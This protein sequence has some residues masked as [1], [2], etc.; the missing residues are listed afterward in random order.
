[1]TPTTRDS[2]K[3]TIRVA[4][5]MGVAGAIASVVGLFVDRERFFH[6]YL[7]AWFFWLGFP[8][9]C[10]GILL[11]HHLLG[12][13][14]GIVTRRLFEAGAATMPLMALLSVPLLFGLPIN[15][16]WAQPGSAAADPKI[17]HKLPYLNVPFFVGRTIFY[18]A[19]WIALAW[20]LNRESR[21]Q[22]STSDPKPTNRLEVFSAPGLI[23]FILT[24]TFASM[25]WL[26]SLEPH[27]YSTIY[28]WMV[29]SG[30]ALGAMALIIVLSAGLSQTDPIL[31]RVF[32][33]QRF[34]DLGTLLF[35]F[36]FF[37]AYLAYSQLVIIWSGNLKHEIPW[38]LRRIAPG[39]TF[40]TASLFVL[41]FVLPFTLLLFRALK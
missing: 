21:K 8:L 36:V 32:T 16:I 7:F 19:I 28:G 41:Q 14:W 40:V 25:D 1:M 34:Q 12:G 39:W 17:A 23:V 22:D 31:E 30:Q 35:T 11:I 2:L 3:R 13:A 9:G 10:I 4:L 5:A 27:W 6:S 29:V 37:W 20:M 15:Y 38:Y 33:A 18:F 24:T 26:M